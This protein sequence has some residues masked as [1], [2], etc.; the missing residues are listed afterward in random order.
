MKLIKKKLKEDLSVQYGSG[1]IETYKKGEELDVVEEATTPLHYYVAFDV[2]I[3]EYIDKSY[4][5][6]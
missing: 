6:D 3:G 2:A 5:E 1:D 4:F